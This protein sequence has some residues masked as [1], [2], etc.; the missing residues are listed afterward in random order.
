MNVSLF[1]VPG[2]YEEKLSRGQK[3]KEGG[4]GR[5]AGGGIHKGL[6]F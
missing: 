1:F 3:M 5:G 2:L 6:T 4:T